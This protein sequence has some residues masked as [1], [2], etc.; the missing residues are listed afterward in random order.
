MQFFYCRCVNWNLL[1]RQSQPGWDLV[2]FGFCLEGSWVSN[3]LRYFPH[4]YYY[5]GVE[6][7][8]NYDNV[9]VCLFEKCWPNEWQHVWNILHFVVCISWK[10]LDHVCGNGCWTASWTIT[11]RFE[12]GQNDQPSRDNKQRPRKNNET[13]KEQVDSSCIRCDCLLKVL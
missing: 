3:N 9:V 5:L 6:A 8:D 4:H 11:V 7:N 10:L 13:I 1:K 12:L 2:R